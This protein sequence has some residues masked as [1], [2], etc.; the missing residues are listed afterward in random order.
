MRLLDN[1]TEDNQDTFLEAFR[2]QFP[3]KS[4]EEKVSCEAEMAKL[5]QGTRDL[6]EYYQLG[7]KILRR[8]G[9]KDQTATTPAMGRKPEILLLE[10]FIGKWIRGLTKS[11]TRTK[12]IEVSDELSTLASAY[13]KALNIEK[14]ELELKK[15]KQAREKEKEIVWLRK[16]FEQT[17]DA[18]RFSE[19]KAAYAKQVQCVEE[20]PE[21]EIPEGLL[22][23]VEA[24]KAAKAKTDQYTNR[25][26]E[27]PFPSSEP[28]PE[29][30]EGQKS[31]NEFVNGTRQFRKDGPSPLCI[32]CGKIGHISKACTGPPLE[33]WEKTILKEKV[34]GPP[35][36]FVKPQRGKMPSQQE[37]SQV[38][39]IGD[40]DSA[41]VK[42]VAAGVAGLEMDDGYL[43]LEVNLGEGSR[44][45][46]RA[47]STVRGA[48]Q[49]RRETEVEDSQTAPPENVN[50]PPTKPVKKRA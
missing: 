40:T 43:P 44:P 35:G 16:C 28:K 38:E 11:R 9:I 27:R 32:E 14:A 37:A 34:F 3:E 19:F 22:R 30:P 29:G 8:L 13:H 10:A 5:V 47:G 2:D 18:S 41:E 49:K 7:V 20:E 42:S 25:R 1:P 21:W 39:A 17:L 23:G 4:T 33:S 50:P 31:Q 6:T 15:D 24:A 26:N 12:L 46:K 36:A 48:A 45:N